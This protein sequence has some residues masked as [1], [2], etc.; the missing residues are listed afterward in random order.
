MGQYRSS[1]SSKERRGHGGAVDLALAVLGLVMFMGLAPS[2]AAGNTSGAR[3]SI[4]KWVSCNEAKDDA[5]GAARAFA[6][7]QNRAFTLVVDCPVRIHV[8]MDIS[9]PIFIESG[10]AVDF[11]G[12]G[13]FLVDNV[14]IPEFV[15]ADS[16]DVVLTHWNVEYVGGVGVQAKIGGYENDGLFVPGREPGGAFNDLR[17]TPWLAANRAIVFD[18]RQGRVNSPWSTPINTGATFFI[19]GD[20]FNLTVDGMDV[21]VPVSAGVDRFVP[22]VFSM[23]YGLKAHETVTT[24]LPV[25]PEWF[26]IPHDLQFT[27]VVFDGT[28]MGWV[29][30]V[31]DALFENIQSHR[32]GDL[33][34]AAGGNVGGVGKW[35][36]PPHLLY[37]NYQAAADPALHNQNIV[38]RNVVDD[39][40]RVGT[41]RDKGGADTL[42]GYALSLKIGCNNCSVDNYRTSRPDGFM[43]VLNSDG[44]KVS[45]VTATYDS[46]FL[47]NVFPGWRFPSNDY[48]NLTFE[49]IVLTDVA[50]ASVQPPIGNMNR[51]SNENIVFTN[52]RIRVHRWAGT[53]K[54]TPNIGGHNNSVSIDYSADEKDGG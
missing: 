30:A 48:K 35:F 27:N 4:R 15:I 49:N 46:S 34:D 32:Y 23:N 31:R 26:A 50:P 1:S 8:G 21:H 33:Q 13:K 47:N 20:S 52:V 36:A 29:G 51:D 11:T 6:A 37:L 10:T 16:S 45:N 40:P 25:T 3:Q 38:I 53:G 28:Y 54:P 18:S 42:S 14:L 19:V 43:D 44:L 24:K 22:V 12:A 41:A 39:G 9:R 5:A 2:H 7:A 17:L